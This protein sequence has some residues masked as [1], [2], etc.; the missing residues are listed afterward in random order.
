MSSTEQLKKALA[1]FR[2]G[3][4]DEA[5]EVCNSLLVEQPRDAGAL[6]L[7]G[8]IAYQKGDLLQ[9]AS[10]LETS[11]QEK[12][13][14]FSVWIK[15]GNILSDL[16]RSNEA[17]QAYARAVGLRTDHPLGHFWQAQGYAAV[18]DMEHAFEAYERTLKL[19][20]D[21]GSAYRLIV[22]T[23][24]PWTKSNMF[25]EELE[26]KTV[27]PSVSAEDKI[28]MHF[29][30]AQLFQDL[31]KSEHMMG[32]LR[33][34]KGLQKNRAPVWR[35]ALQKLQTIMCEI[36]STARSPLS[37]APR[38]ES[39]P[40]FVVGVPRSGSTLLESMLARHSA[41]AA[42]SETHIVPRVLKKIQDDFTGQDF[43]EGLASLQEEAWRVLAED[44]AQSYATRGAP[45]PFVTDKLLANGQ[46]LGLLHRLAPSAKVIY[47]R[48]NPEDAAISIFQNHFWEQTWP[49]LCALDDIGHYCG[50]YEHVME[51]WRQQL[52][53]VIHDVWYERLVQDPDREIKCVLDHLG[54]PFETACLT[55]HEGQRAIQ[56][57]SQSQV[58]K[59]LYQ[60][61]V[62]KS[63]AHAKDLGVFQE[64]YRNALQ[65]PQEG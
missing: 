19:N 20:P 43:P 55:F 42:G 34:A 26:L 13:D 53:D 32:H 59:P 14:Q 33:K 15:L 11:L 63:V 12:S 27:N 51:F 65:P 47:V 30:L 50:Q 36:F 1:Y 22:K 40:I 23:G 64:A 29:A 54:L 41:I 17:Q 37:P 45:K 5:Q 61:S 9:A 21:F 58:I 28:H 16:N 62:G 46:I 44:L 6:R 4:L 35:P 48:R 38:F 49:Q 7:L 18:G 60:T 3:F 57:L 2:A 24:N 25:R 56:T 8:Q 39:V 10:L 31:G 52:P